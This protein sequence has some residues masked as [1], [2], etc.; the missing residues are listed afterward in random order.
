MLPRS[1][2]FRE[3]LLRSTGIRVSPHRFPRFLDICYTRTIIDRGI[4][5]FRVKRYVRSHFH[6]ATGH[7]KTAQSRWRNENRTKRNTKRYC[8]FLLCSA[9]DQTRL[10]RDK[11][12]TSIRDTRWF[13][14]FHRARCSVTLF[15]VLLRAYR[16]TKDRRHWQRDQSK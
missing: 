12:R 7:V 14:Q 11:S 2:F 15:Q 9:R 8:H 6:R 16:F 1:I 10:A 5:R 13:F 3:E 4:A